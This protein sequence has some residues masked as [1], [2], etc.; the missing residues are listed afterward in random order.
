L[1]EIGDRLGE[2]GG[3]GVG[4]D[5]CGYLFGLSKFSAIGISHYLNTNNYY[6]PIQLELHFQQFNTR[7]PQ[8]IQTLRI[9]IPHSNHQ[10]LHHQPILPSLQQKEPLYI[11]TLH[12]PMKIHNLHLQFTGN[13]L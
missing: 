13:E 7:I 4:F 10:I 12:I 1:V 5:D 2:I 6:N 11:Q 9:K 8:T 3:F